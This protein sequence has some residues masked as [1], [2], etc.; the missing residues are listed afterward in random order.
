MVIQRQVRELATILN[1]VIGRPVSFSA[2]P[3]KG[4]R[5]VNIRFKFLIDL[6]LPPDRAE[7]TLMGLEDVY[8]RPRYGSKPH[9]MLISRLSRRFGWVSADDRAVRQQHTLL[10]VGNQTR[11]AQIC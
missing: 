8:V 7:E 11:L 5:G 2:R 1:L 6:F 10:E 4:R 9:N 3:L